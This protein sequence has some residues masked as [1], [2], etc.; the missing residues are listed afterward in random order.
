MTED[1]TDAGKSCNYIIDEYGNTP[2]HIAVMKN[3]IRGM[4]KW[5]KKISIDK[6]NKFGET[7][8]S[9]AVEYDS[10]LMIYVNADYLN[11]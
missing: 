8:R 7:P 1:I 6:K 2:L 5:I 11:G 10:D 9:L 4:I 3:D